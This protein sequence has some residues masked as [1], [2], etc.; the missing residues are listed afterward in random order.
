MIVKGKKKLLIEEEEY[1][2]IY[3]TRKKKIEK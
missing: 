2:L 1:K 3:R